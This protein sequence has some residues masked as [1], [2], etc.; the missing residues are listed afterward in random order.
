MH[1]Q[2]RARLQEE[3]PE[4]EKLSREACPF[5]VSMGVRVHA[6]AAECG[7]AMASGMTMAMNPAAPG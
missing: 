4:V 3:M 1:V 5:D 2:T 7:H 6:M